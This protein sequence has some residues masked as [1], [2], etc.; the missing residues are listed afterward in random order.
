MAGTGLVVALGI[1]LWI[2]R[3]IQLVPRQGLLVIVVLSGGAV[4][5]ALAVTRRLDLTATT[6]ELSRRWRTER[7]VARGLHRTGTAVLH[8]RVVADSAVIS[9]LVVGSSSVLVVV[10]VGPARWAP[11][12]PQVPRPAGTA[13]LWRAWVD[14]CEAATALERAL[15]GRP[16]ALRVRPAVVTDAAELPAWARPLAIWPVSATPDALLPDPGADPAAR[17]RALEEVRA[18]TRPAAS[19]T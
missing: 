8:D 11:W 12:R 3:G 9:H 7:R 14:A 19:T 17:L 18:V 16:V 13:A 4:A 5:L 1:A 15:V 2:R 6:N 10:D